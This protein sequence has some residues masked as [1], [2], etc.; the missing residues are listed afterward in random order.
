MKELELQQRQQ[1]YFE[2]QREAMI[3]MTANQSNIA[4]RS[5]KCG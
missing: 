2:Q 4:V 3:G 5:I 1:S